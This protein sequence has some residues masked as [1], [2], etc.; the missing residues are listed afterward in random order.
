MR[1]NN[2]KK[3][4]SAFIDNE[5]KEKDY[6]KTQKHIEKC[7]SCSTFYKDISSLDKKIHNLTYKEEEENLRKISLKENPYYQ[8]IPQRRLSPILKPVYTFA[9]LLL[10]VTGIF[11]VNKSY[12][13]PYYIESLSSFSSAPIKLML[14][15]GRLTVDTNETGMHTSVITPWMIIEPMGTVFTVFQGPN[16]ATVEVIAGSI[17]IINKKENNKKYELYEKEIF[18]IINDNENYITQIIKPEKFVDPPA[19]D[20]NNIVIESWRE[21][22]N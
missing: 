15:E 4:I 19:Q 2:L 10:I 17:T 5:L 12:I 18:E 1:H 9:A 14:D 21:K 22:T 7:K 11:F 3:K 20:V 16:A 6:K 8:F 13:S